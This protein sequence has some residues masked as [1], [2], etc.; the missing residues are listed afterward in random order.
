M[1][2]IKLCVI[3]V[4]ETD[5]LVLEQLKQ[6]IKENQK[7]SAKEI[8]RVWTKS[9]PLKIQTAKDNNLLYIPIWSQNISIVK[10]EIEKI[11]Q[12]A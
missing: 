1:S 10:S 3:S 11:L 4:I 8:I 6:K 12:R 5:E 2:G 9:D 7:S